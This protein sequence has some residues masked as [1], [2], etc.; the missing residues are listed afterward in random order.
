MR[1][2]E[3]ITIEK[4]VNGGQGLGRWPDG[5]TA[6]VWNVLPG[7]TVRVNVLKQKTDYVTGVA[8]DVLQ[9]SSER[10]APRDTA[11]LST[12]P[13]QI[14]SEQAEDT[15][16]P[17]ILRETFERAGVET[18]QPS[19]AWQAA[20]NSW[21]Y[22]NK[23]EYSFFGD[24]QG[25]HLALYER[26]TNRKQIVTGS[27]LAMPAIDQAAQTICYVL[28]QHTIR[29]S[30]LKTLVVRASQTGAVAASL[31]VTDKQFPDL[32]NALQQSVSGLRIHYSTPKSPASVITKTLYT[33][34]DPTLVDTVAGRD[35]RYS[36]DSFFQVNVPMFEQS[37]RAVQAAVAA[38]TK[39]VDMY[40]G[41]GTIGLSVGASHL[42]EVAA[43]N[44]RMA[45]QNAAAADTAVM[46]ASTEQALEYI[47]SDATVLF[48]PPRAGLH[49]KV[50]Q[51]LLD[52]QPDKI[53]YLSCEPA[54]QARDI[55]KLQS[56][57]DLCQF[58]GY[59]FFPR[60]PHIESLVVLQKR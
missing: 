16:K 60:T 1:I 10:V 45:T 12:S 50:T 37:L 15:Y 14:M 57:Y 52:N 2:V 32:M 38:D 30:Q 34:K 58:S 51:A 43:E 8:V 23:M 59:N 7:E 26:G 11:Y 17:A 5:R 54:T 31:Y 19:L 39:I 9:A 18:R 29:A 27:S 47:E 25:L 33:A 46:Q 22:R 44:V 48:D 4:L 20:T 13:W 53:V 35:F 24:E 55:A 36:V 41:V 49:P 28:Q 3:D 42:I 40:A 21:Q 56:A 6:F